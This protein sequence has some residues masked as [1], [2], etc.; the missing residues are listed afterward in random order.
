MFYFALTECRPLRCL[1]DA[2]FVPSMALSRYTVFWTVSCFLL[3]PL[4][5][6]S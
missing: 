6:A 1:F 3:E 4:L 5:V 2:T